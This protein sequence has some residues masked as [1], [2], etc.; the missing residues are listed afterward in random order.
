[1]LEKLFFCIGRL[2]C[3]VLESGSDI[4]TLRPTRQATMIMRND[5]ILL[6]WCDNFIKV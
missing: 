4:D 6:L 3:W 2:A 1:M 5:S